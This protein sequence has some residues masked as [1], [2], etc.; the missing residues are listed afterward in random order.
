M[1]PA[2]GPKKRQLLAAAD[3][4]VLPSFSEG[5]SMAILEAAAAGLPVLLT[6][7]CNFPELAAAGA[8]IEVPAGPVGIPEGLAKILELSAA[9]RKLMGS[10]GLELVKH[11]YTWPAVAKEMMRVYDWLAKKGSRPDCVQTA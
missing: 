4:F 3:A 10:R 7:E 1:G 8:A 5:F 6:K 9:Q 2:Y 11:F